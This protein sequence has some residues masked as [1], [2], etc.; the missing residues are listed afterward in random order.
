[1]I[2]KY[3][4]VRELSSFTGAP[5]NLHSSMILS[6]K[7]LL[8]YW[9]YTYYDA[10]KNIDNSLLLYSDNFYSKYLFSVVFPEFVKFLYNYGD[11]IKEKYGLNVYMELL[12][13]ASNKMNGLERGK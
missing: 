4:D 12:N 1:M 8:E 11:Y 13:Y 5:L 2:L 7:A 9:D 6:M 3:A 10:L